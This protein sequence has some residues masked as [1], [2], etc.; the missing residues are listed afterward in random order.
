MLASCAPPSPVSAPLSTQ[1]HTS[2]MLSPTSTP[3]STQTDTT[4]TVPTTNVPP[5][6]STPAPANLPT[7]TKSEQVSQA[8]QQ[9]SIDKNNGTSGYKMI[10]DK[11][12]AIMLEIPNEWKDV[13]I[14]HRIVD[15]EIIIICRINTSTRVNILNHRSASR[16]PVGGP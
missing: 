8:D 7:P 16:G 14:K 9:Q 1:T 13:D 10:T 2:Q 11:S 6:T 5:G 15:G 4:Q 12:G 3:P